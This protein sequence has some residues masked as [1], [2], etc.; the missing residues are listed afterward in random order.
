MR[1]LT[2]NGN[3]YYLFERDLT[4]NHVSYHFCFKSW[5]NFN[6]FG[7]I[8]KAQEKINNIFSEENI[9]YVLNDPRF[10]KAITPENKFISDPYFHVTL[11]GAEDNI[12]REVNNSFFINTQYKY[13][14]FT[15]L[16]SNLNKPTNFKCGF[17]IDEFKKI[18]HDLKSKSYEITKLFKNEFLD[19][20][21]AFDFSPSGEI[22]HENL[23]I[24]I[25][26]KYSRINFKRWVSILKN[27][28]SN[29]NSNFFEKYDR[30]FEHYNPYKF[31]FHLKIKIYK[32][33]NP[34]IKFYRS[35]GS[36]NPY[37]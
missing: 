34:T 36:S 9:F 12:Y 8:K 21:Y 7:K 25:I 2:M 19:V 37:I 6:T 23:N 1:K 31:H 22:I 16:I 32:Q 5:E 18:P 27:N 29:I 15:K 13:N 30:L 3:V 17:T 35:Y 4:S 14:Y 10:H 20:I 26:P 24:E 11:Y 28:F 33:Q